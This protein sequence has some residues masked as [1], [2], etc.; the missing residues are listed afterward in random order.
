MIELLFEPNKLV[1]S[2]DQMFC[3]FNTSQTNVS[4]L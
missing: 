2:N 4:D 1:E 3:F